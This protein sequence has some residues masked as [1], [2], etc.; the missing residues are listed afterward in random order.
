MFRRTKIVST[1]GP[2]SDSEEQLS[3][4]IAAGV[5]VF[6]LNFS[7]GSHKDKLELIERIRKVAAEKG[8]NVAILGDL[9]GPKIRTGLMK[10]GYMELVTGTEVVVTTSTV[11]GE[12]TTIPT[13]YENLPND[14]RPGDRIL[15]DDGLMDLVVLATEGQDVRCRVVTGGKLKDR[16]GINLP[17]VKVSAPAMTEKDVEDLEFCIAQQVDFIA[18]SFVRKAA[19]VQHLKDILAAKNFAPMIISKIEK[20]EAVDA[21]DEILEVTDA[22]MVARGD[23]GVEISPEKVP[24]IQKMIIQK[25]NAAGKPVITATQMLESMISNPRP[26]RAEVSDVANAILDGT[27]AIML[28]GETAAGKYPVEAVQVMDHVA[29]DV[30]SSEEYLG[31]S[32]SLSTGKADKQC[33]TEAIGQGACQIAECVDARAIFAFTQ[34]GSTAALV[35]KY[36][37]NRPIYAM[38][39]SAAV[40][41]RMAL[42]SGVRA[43]CVEN[44][45]ATEQQIVAVEKAAL[46]AEVVQSGDVTVVTMGSPVVEAGS[47]NLVKVH[48]VIKYR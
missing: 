10:G 43:I 22:V 25:C 34:T 14:V 41:R 9:Q 44:Q 46:Q 19:D 21:F 17:G 31:R 2:A 11:A 16:K 37:P 3:A 32:V 23:L 33:L 36:R 20:P 12:G 35:S 6:R 8:S 15:L 38:T 26:T 18:L 5:N 7:H 4:L 24:L 45:E 29:R 42:Y 47:T 13:I 1:L 48:T 39:P 27:D 30:E 28:S 40:K